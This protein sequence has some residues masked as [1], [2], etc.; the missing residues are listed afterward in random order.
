MAVDNS[1]I[2]EKIKTVS[3]VSLF[4]RLAARYGFAISNGARKKNRGKKGTVDPQYKIIQKP[5]G[6]QLDSH[7]TKQE[8]DLVSKL[9]SSS[10]MSA[11]IQEYF[12]DW[13]NDTQNTY[14]NIYER[15]QRLDAFTNLCDNEG[16]IK[17]ACTLVASET[18]MLTEVNAFTV[19]SEDTVWAA[20]CNALLSDVWGYKAPVIYS[21]A[22]SIFLY[23]EAFR[24]KEVSS[25]GIVAMEG[26]KVNEIVERIEFKPSQCANFFAEMGGY[27]AGRSTGF[28]VNMT[29]PT[30][31]SFA[32]TNLSFNS[33]NNRVTYKS[34]DSLLAEYLDNISDSSSNEFFTSHLLGY[35]VANDQ[36]VA[37]WQVTHFRFNEGISEFWPYGQ[38]PLL[39]ALAAYKQLQR[40]MGLDDLKNLLSFPVYMY[41]VKTGGATTARAFDI[42]NTVKEEFE[43][44]GLMSYSSGMEG[45]SLLTNIWT[46]D[47][48]VTIE[49]V[50]G[51]SNENTGATDKLKF[52]E[53]RVSAASGIPLSYLD[54][55]SEG[56]QMS[57][58]A[59]IALFRPFRNLVEQI[60]NIILEQVENDI[61]LHYSMLNV[62][63][64][65]F[66]L[67]LNVENP[68]A[69]DDLSS[70]LQLADDVLEAVANI[71]GLDDKAQLPRTVKMD[72]LS[73]YGGLSKTE[74]GNY[75]ATLEEEGADEGESGEGDFGDFDE[76]G[77]D[78]G[79]DEG[80]MEEAFI[81]GKKNRL[82]ETRYKNMGKDK[83]F[84]NLVESLGSLKTRKGT[85][86]FC[87]KPNDKFTAE[88]LS[89]IKEKTNGRR[90]KKKLKG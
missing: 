63:V 44:V 36:M 50:E 42:V 88:M 79:E 54:P 82:I 32:N 83:M 10:K 9:L 70:K 6:S 66:V 86:H 59:L 77:G 19:T 13:V 5:T 49:K 43:N 23:G 12:E 39:A 4:Q 51:G 64:P 21:L 57:G 76:E 28:T 22:W 38:P 40:A 33:T 85:S 20:G 56:F 78:E 89:F 74:L 48:L 15:Q 71:L 11:T 27:S 75:A 61:L 52:F 65:K 34:K 84:Y 46:S 30:N 68:V 31:G 55:T 25:A 7:D 72:I 37:P 1:E 24:A 14:A 18:A 26:I 81:R 67:T 53:Q 8:V 90:G 58:V 62:K 69:T 73:R 3:R 47:D 29:Q 17:N 80:D 45:P 41:K 16:L 87:Y 60:R 35:R 2:S